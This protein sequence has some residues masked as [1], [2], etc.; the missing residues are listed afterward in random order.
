ML[1]NK[2]FVAGVVKSFCPVIVYLILILC[3]FVLT[4]AGVC[5]NAFPVKTSNDFVIKKLT[6][7]CTKCGRLVLCAK[8][9]LALWRIEILP[10]W[11]LE[12]RLQVSKWPKKYSQC[13]KNLKFQYSSMNLRQPNPVFYSIKP[14]ID[15]GL[16]GD[17]CF[18]SFFHD[19]IIKLFH[20]NW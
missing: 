8:E 14:R 19:V 18:T 12:S 6:E 10:L 7:A 5:S 4:S 2:L 17:F 15:L 20:K 1:R 16:F 3:I 9:H 13:S 11:R